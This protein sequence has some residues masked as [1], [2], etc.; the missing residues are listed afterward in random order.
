MNGMG[1][2]AIATNPNN[3]PA[4]RGVSLS[5]IWFA[6]NGNTAPNKERKI[7]VAAKAEAA[8]ARYVSII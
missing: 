4:Q 2:I 5:N 6:N 7:I 8:D 3:D 1:A